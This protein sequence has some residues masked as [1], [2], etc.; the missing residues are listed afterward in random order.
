LIVNLP[1]Q[2]W[3]AIRLAQLPGEGPDPF[4]IEREFERA[5]FDFE[6]I[7]PYPKPWNPGAG[8][9]GAY[10]GI[11]PLRALRVLLARRKAGIILTGS[12]SP[13]L[14]LTALRRFFFFRA[15]I[16][17]W[18]MSWS[19]GWAFRE[20]L[21]RQTVPKADRTIVV[22][23]NQIGLAQQQ[24][25][26]SAKPV[27]V[28]LYTDVDFFQPQAGRDVEPLPYVVSIGLDKGRD[29]DLLIKA[30]AGL[31][32]PLKIKAGRY[33]VPLDRTLFPHVE[34]IDRFLP[35]RELRDL[36]DRAAVV[37]IT[38]HDTPNACG[39]TSLMEAMAMGKPVVVSNNP[40][41]ADYLPPA[42]LE[43]AIV[44]PIGD[45]GALRGAIADLL[46][47]PQKALAMGERA[48]AYAQERFHPR[49]SLQIV[50]DLCWAILEGRRNRV[51]RT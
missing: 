7:D 32:P 51:A 6:T 38:T 1:P 27:F 35:Y 46:A 5:G 9:H 18:E 13:A 44:A 2:R 15:P 8:R 34:I 49:A 3:Q 25:G 42:E 14:L 28:P 41:L 17:I 4:W 39:V 12:E 30:T 21:C 24:F 11:D 48:R 19:P 29:F 50:T 16:V 33:P 37:A 45:A 47:N 26:P 22:G 31:G 23:S 20:W 40:A 36:Y 10:M 43:A